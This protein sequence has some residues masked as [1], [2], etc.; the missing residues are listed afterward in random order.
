MRPEVSQW[1][2]SPGHSKQAKEGS[3]R[4]FF[5]TKGARPAFQ[6]STKMDKRDYIIDQAGVVLI[7][8]LILIVLAL[9]ISEIKNM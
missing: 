2:A 5:I 6:K 3:T 4:L 7:V 9:G 8:V 1:T